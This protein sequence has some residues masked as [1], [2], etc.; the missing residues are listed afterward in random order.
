MGQ[1]R[2]P[3]S[4]N[5]ATTKKQWTLR[6]AVEGYA[7]QDVRGIAV[8]RD[9]LEECGVQEAATLLSDHGMTVTGH[10]R[11]G[12]FP[13]TDKAG[14]QAAV[15][16]NL[17]AI[18]EAVAI[19]AQCLVL[20]CGGLP[21]GSKDITGARAMVRDGIAAILP[22]ARASGMP[23][24][25]EPLHPMY[26]A[27]RACINTMAQANDICDELGAGVGIAVDVYHVWW[28]PELNRQIDR[29]AKADPHRLLAFHICD[30]LVP[31]K[32]MLSDRGMM[33]DGVI[34]ITDIRSIME[35]AGYEGFAEVEIFST[36]WWN[37][38]PD[39][40]VSTCIERH[41]NAS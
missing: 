26:A 36:R 25:I 7:K 18:D 19:G 9:K 10:C 23:L 20:V 33:G 14:L 1:I 21:E 17:R 11:G 37:T 6:E 5:Q 35:N 24:A 40:V 32:D 16:D 28:D 39:E 31:T 30:W 22:H 41:R 34:D 38:D 4:I 3:L 12:M 8:W 27:D 13:A 29:A 2:Y 15:D